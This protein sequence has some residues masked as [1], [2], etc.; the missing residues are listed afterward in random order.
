M[1]VHPAVGNYSGTLVNALLAH[2]KDLSGINGEI[3]PGIVH[4]LDKETTGAM[5]A[6]KMIQGSFKFSP[7]NKGHDTTQVC[8]NCPW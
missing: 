6:A 2:C 7:T 5:V 8:S 4:R 1:V 3:R